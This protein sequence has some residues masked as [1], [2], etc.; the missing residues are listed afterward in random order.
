MSAARNRFMLFPVAGAGV[1]RMRLLLLAGVFLAGLGHA[2][3]CGEDVQHPRLYV[4]SKDVDQARETLTP[5]EFEALKN[6]QFPDHYDGVGN[7]DEMVFA[8]LVADN[9]SAKRAVVAV[10]FQAFEKLLAAMP[11]TINKRSGPHNYSRHAGLAASLADAAFAGDLLTFAQRAE[12]RKQILAVNQLLHHPDYWDPASG[13]SSLNPN[14]T[15]SANG[16][17]M[18]FAALIPD[19]PESAGWMQSA[20]ADLQEEVDHWI[21]PQGGMIEC[22]HYSMV[23]FDQWIGSFLIA[24]N[25]GMADDGNL[26]HP[27]L[28]RAMEWFGNISTPRDINSNNLRRWPTLGH[29][30]ANERTCA[31]GMMACIWKDRDPE[32]AAAMAWMD[33]EHGQFGEPGIFSYYPGVMGYRRFFRNSDVQPR[34]PKW[35]SRVYSETGVLLRNTLGSDRETVLHLI[36]GRNHSHYFNDSGS[37]TIWGKGR[38]LLTEDDYQ[39]RRNPESREAHSMP[40]K[41]A[42]LNGERVM[43]IR[44]FSSS[45]ELD[46]VS[47]T[48]RGWQ[49]QVVFVK[50]RDPLQPNYFVLADTLD[51]KSVPTIWRLFVGGEIVQSEGGVTVRGEQDVDLDI[52]FVRPREPQLDV[53]EDRI[54]LSVAGAGTVTVVLYP[55]LKTERAPKVTPLLDGAGVEVQTSGGVDRVVVGPEDAEYSWGGRM[56]RGRVGLLSNR[57]GRKALVQVGDCD[58]TPGWAG[59][60]RELRVIRWNGPQYPVFPDE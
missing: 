39:N 8:A 12:L 57:A 13:K 6:R 46:Y 49:R 25:A 51:A 60:D 2:A 58:V 34:V 23:I 24:R 31:F 56:F 41:P 28:R 27:Q 48:R 38:E 42:T 17:R 14:M 47:G 21:D 11:D 1:F 35:G 10:V 59:G 26:F 3:I 30:Y 45:A 44:E 53:H 19:H 33:R 55:R 37:I 4:T 16:Y 36:G 40:D 18:M 43:A 54:E 15:T 29:T 5:P 22:P 20:Y 52:V 9:P 7:P 32:F 50:D